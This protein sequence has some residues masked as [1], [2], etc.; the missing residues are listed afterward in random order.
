MPSDVTP[1]QFAEAV[2]RHVLWWF[3]RDIEFQFTWAT[4][5][6]SRGKE[7][8]ALAYNPAV[9]DADL[10]RL[11]SLPQLKRLY[12]AGTQIT[13]ANLATL[14]GLSQLR[15][16]ALIDTAVTD[17][18]LEHLKGLHVLKELSLKHTRVTEQGIKRLRSALPKLK[19]VSK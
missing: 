18:G 5:P 19:T 1:A 11:R 12:L 9:T 4:N 7:T 14:S 8:V 6:S 10:A 13:D 17:A 16:L 15:E 3:R 2:E